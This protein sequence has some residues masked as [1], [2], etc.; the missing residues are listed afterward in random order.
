MFRKLANLFVLFVSVTV[1][2]SAT[3][4]HL[5]AKDFG[6]LIAYYTFDNIKDNT[7][8][9]EV[10]NKKFA[11]KI[12]GVPKIEAGKFGKGISFAG[13]AEP[14]RQY[15]DIEEVYPYGDTDLSISLWVKVPQGANNNTRVGIIMGNY[16]VAN[17]CNIELHGLGQVRWWWNNGERDHKAKQDL[18]DGKWH[19]L[20][21]IRDK[22]NQKFIMYIDGKVEMEADGAVTDVKPLP[23]RIGGDKRGDDSHWFH[24]SMDDF[25]IWTE[26][27]DANKIKE[28]ME[29]GIE[30][31]LAVTT[32]GKL[33]VL[34][35]EVKS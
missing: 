21:F 4:T 26:V 12:E 17:N 10:D 19:H 27:L 7:V 22:S 9:N 28:I 31:Y 6:N 1:F 11:G 29:K 34:W 25:A 35:G 13:K 8:I 20:V 16:N 30:K 5:F 2:M 3:R 15:I 33:A 24:G 14:K 18:R 23:Q 32:K